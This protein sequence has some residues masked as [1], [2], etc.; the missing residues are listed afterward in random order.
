MI[1]CN[2][3]CGK[4]INEIDKQGRPRR[5]SIGH[6][7]TTYK[8]GSNS[9]RW[10]GGKI[11]HT[12]GYVRIYSPDHLFKDNQGY[13]FEHRLVMEKYIGRYLT[14]E[15]HIH[16]INGIKDDNRIKNLQILSHS[17]H[18]QTTNKKNML[19]RHC[20]ICKSNITYIDKF[21]WTKWYKHD[22]GFICSKCNGKIKRSVI[23]RI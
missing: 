3:G 23:K 18:S 13:V 17:E 5:F 12:S 1:K 4:Y 20:I 19:D 11:K 10:K 2:C 9:H 8:K 21:G 22:G 6:R 7:I 14:K 16:H 15:E